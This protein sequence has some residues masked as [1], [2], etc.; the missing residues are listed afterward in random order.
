VLETSDRIGGRVATDEVDGFLLDRGFQV[1][2]DRYPDA[3]AE[4]DL[5]ALDLRGFYAGSLVRY[6]GRSYR[7]A[8]PWRDP[9]A[10][11]RSLFTPVFAMTDGPA[12]TAVRLATLARSSDPTSWTHSGDTA[13]AYLERRLSTRAVERFL[14][15]FFGGVFL[16]RSLA[17]PRPY[18]EFIFAMFARGRATLPSQ[19]MQAIPAQ[20]ADGLPAGTVQLERRVVGVDDGHVALAGGERLP[21]THV[22]VATDGST[23][24]KLTGGQNTTWSGCITLYFAAPTAPYDEPILTLNGDGP[25][26]GPVNHVCIP[27]NVAP[28]YAP[29]GQALISA[30]VI[31]T[32]DADIADLET[33]ARS[34]LHEW[35]GNAVRTWRLLRAYRID[36]ALPHMG[37]PP[38]T[39][40]TVV[41][42]G[43]CRL[44]V[45]GDHVESPSINGAMASGARAARSVIDDIG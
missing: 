21:A 7:I 8:D 6:A 12:M 37:S 40:P 34:Q 31:G 18:F 11:M 5:E 1:F 44:V 25:A 3:R 26:A 17:V 10:G 39:P 45:A 27:S 23:A 4:L 20:L 24:G 13:G 29:G 19:G 42:M 38:I 43:G 28:A 15:P 32:P 33:D 35:F 9:V 36:R 41:T 14:R 2:L 22:I 30:T 16:D